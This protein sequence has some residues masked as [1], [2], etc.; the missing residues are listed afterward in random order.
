[1]KAVTMHPMF[2]TN[3]T[4]TTRPLLH[5]IQP[6][7]VY[8]ALLLAISL[9]ALPGFAQKAKRTDLKQQ[10][11]TPDRT[12]LSTP[13]QQAAYALGM[14]IGIGLKGLNAP[15]IDLDIFIQGICDTLVKGKSLITIE[16]AQQ[17]KQ[18]FFSKLQAEQG[19]RT[20]IQGIAYLN[21]NA[22]KPGVRV[23]ESGLQFKPL[24]KGRGVPAREGDEVVVHYT[25]RLTDGT[26]F[27]SSIKRGR[28]FIFPIQGER[29]I[30]GWIEVMQ[31]MREGD[32]WEVTIPSALA[33]SDRPMR[34][35]PPNSV[36]IF[37]V[38]LLKVNP[39]S[40]QKNAYNQVAEPAGSVSQDAEADADGSEN[41]D[42]GGGGYEDL[43]RGLEGE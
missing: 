19:E 5:K 6:L 24:I 40:E 34:V 22:R 38:E 2:P 43:L 18:A 16:E 21:A 35:I 13:D 3:P 37:Q 9:V 7:R 33:Y 39:T 8:H 15:N 17:V 29:V 14:E 31:L 27:D 23:T 1:M 32:K 25:G 41:G 26:E 42:Q 4:P 36:L 10:I 30:A 11:R 20:K 12:T 28:P